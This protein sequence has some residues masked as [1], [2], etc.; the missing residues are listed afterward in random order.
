MFHVIKY[1]LLNREDRHF[2]M[3]N[4]MSLQIPSKRSSLRSKR[5]FGILPWVEGNG[6]VILK[7]SHF[8]VWI[9]LVNRSLLE[10][11]KPF[12]R[13][14]C[15]LDFRLVDSSSCILQY[16]N[17]CFFNALLHI[18]ADFCCWNVLLFFLLFIIIINN[19]K[20]IIIIIQNGCRDKHL[21]STWNVETGASWRLLSCCS[22]CFPPVKVIPSWTSQGLGP[23]E[24][25]KVPNHAGFSY[26]SWRIFSRGKVW[27][28]SSSE[29]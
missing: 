17:E 1:H 14:L 19:Q 24:L 8:G 7:V 20:L 15:D 25:R 18:T 26:C 2:E 29:N 23:P 3:S 13:E 27:Y 9:R 28:F 11:W 5:L 22:S 10:A 6:R 16:G 21:T 12:V 4:S